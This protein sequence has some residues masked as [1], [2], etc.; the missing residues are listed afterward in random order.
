MH[1]DEMFE[2][3]KAQ[4]ILIVDASRVVR[5][6]LSHSVRSHYSVSEA[7]DGEKAWHSLVLDSKIVAVISGLS[8]TDRDGA[9]LLEQIRGNRLSRISSLP[10]YQLASDN[11]SEAERQHALQLGV[12]AFIPKTM[13]AATLGELLEAVEKNIAAGV[14]HSSTIGLD[15][16]GARMKRMAGLGTDI[17]RPTAGADETEPH[18]A[19]QAELVP[20]LPEEQPGAASGSTACALI[21]GIDDYGML[22]GRFG[23]RIADKVVIKFSTLL[24]SKIRAK[25]NLQLLADGRIGITLNRV[26]REQCVTFARRVCKA[27]AAATISVGGQQIKA[28]VSAG[29]A[30]APQ[31]GGD[32]SAEAL[33][34]LALGR[35]EAAVAAGGNRIFQVGG[36]GENPE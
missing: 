8:L 19:E 28:T 1:R 3:Q 27:L 15:D 18:A 11:L 33:F 13:P 29:V 30:A 12:T 17:V 7:D 22:R 32:L 6:S 34:A 5:A 14:G 2:A 23:Q 24:R 31:D 26:D 35:L 21:F 4:K 36:S 16:L 20:R 9:G 25:E 10:F